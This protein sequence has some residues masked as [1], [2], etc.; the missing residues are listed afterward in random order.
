[1]PKHKNIKLPAKSDYEDEFL[2]QLCRIYG[3]G[4][5][6]PN[7]PIKSSDPGVPPLPLSVS[8]EVIPELPDSNKN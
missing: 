3:L 4:I 1:M 2:I 6:P 7:S 5:S 8:G